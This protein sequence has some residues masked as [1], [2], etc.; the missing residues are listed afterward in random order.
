VKKG[1]ADF[2]ALEGPTRPLA[3]HRRAV[4]GETFERPG[5]GRKRPGAAHFVH[6]AGK[7]KDLIGPSRAVVTRDMLAVGQQDRGQIVQAAR[8]T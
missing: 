7:A 5:Q 1:G 6:R 3:N 2:S 4:A 8:F